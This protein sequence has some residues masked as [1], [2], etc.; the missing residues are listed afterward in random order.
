M[1]LS[2]RQ[3]QWKINGSFTISRGSKTHADVVIVELAEH[4]LTDREDSQN[5]WIIGRGE[6]VPYARYGESIQ[7]VIEQIEAVRPQIENASLTHQQLLSLL[8]AGAAR[9]AIDCALWDLTCKRNQ[10]SIW[11][12][13]NINPQPLITAFTLSIGSIE[14]MQQTAKINASRPL[15]KLKLAGDSLDLARVRAVRDAAPKSKIILD[16]NEAWTEEI[17]RNLIPQLLPLDITM[18]EQPFA[19][20]ND[21][22]LTTLPQPIPICADE[23]CHGQESLPS[24]A[25]KYQ[26]INIKLDKTGGLTEAFAVKQQ[27]QDLGLK[28][29][30]GCMVGSSLSMAPASVIA[31]DAD[32]VDLDGPLLL[33]EDIDSGIEFEGSIMMPFSDELW[34]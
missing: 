34:G 32:I 31:Q 17:Y 23:S 20:D 3:K 25:T 1:K 10:Q 13:L 7:S 21:D 28:I 33:A 27:A 5:S 11:Q 16:A 12:Q 14:E 4:L 22:I 18:I 26:M 30:I 19:A 29:M 8:P 9:N 2:I 15:L 24:L 6:C